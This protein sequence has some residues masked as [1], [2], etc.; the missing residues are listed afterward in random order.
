MT[1]EQFEQR[2]KSDY[3]KYQKLIRLTGAQID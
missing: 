2:L 3:T 1:P